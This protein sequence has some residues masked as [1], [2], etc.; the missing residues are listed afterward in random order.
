LAGLLPAGFELA[1]VYAA[2]VCTQAHQGALARRF[3]Q[4]LAGS[5]AAAAAARASAGFQ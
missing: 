5:D 1:T 3:V 2:A 4:L